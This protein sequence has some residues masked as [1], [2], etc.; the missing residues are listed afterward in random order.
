MGPYLL[1]ERIGEGGMG[2]VWKAEQ[3]A[4]VRRTVALKL[5]K[6][7]MDSR[8]VLARFE[9]ERQA[10]ALM[11]HPCIAKVFDAGTTAQG[12]PYFAME[13]VQ[14]TPI[15]EYCDRRRL[16]T[17]QRLE[18]F[19][20]V[21][22]GVQHAHQ[23]AVL[24][25][26]L[27]PS[28]IL[29]A[30][31][32]EKPLPKIIDFGVAKATT[33]K[34]T[35]RTMYTAMG[36][37]IGT[38]EYMSPEQAELTGEDVDTR[39]DVYSLG[40]VLYELMVG[41][42]PFEP[43]ELRKA[44][45]E[46]IRKMIREQDPPRPSTKLSTLGEQT[47][48]IAQCRATGPKRLSSQLKG[49]LDWIVMRCL[50]KDRN[51]R[52]GSPQELGQDVRR[53]LEHEPVLAGPPSPAY[54]AKKFVRRNRLGVSVAAA[55]L[56]VLVAF[57]A[58]TVVQSRRIATERD[59]A[60]QEAE[61][62]ERVSAFLAE[63][64][65]DINPHRLG[66]TLFKR[67]RTRVAEEQRD[68]IDRF[69]FGVNRADV[70]SH[71]LREEILGRAS[72]TIEVRL[73]DDPL[74][75]ANLHQTLGTSYV[76]IG[77]TEDAI[78]QLERAVE[79]RTLELGPKHPATLR[80]R[81]DHAVAHHGVLTAAS[82]PD[83]EPLSRMRRVYEDRQDI[84]GPDHPE[85]LES[86][87]QL[88][89]MHHATGQRAQADSVHRLV[90]DSRLR[91][92]GADHSR[93]LVSMHAVA[94]MSGHMSRWDEADSLFSIALP[95][96]ERALGPDDRETLA[97]KLDMAFFY[98]HNQ[99][100]HELAARLL[101]DVVEARR[102]LLGRNHPATM[103]AAGVLADIY[104]EWH[105]VEENERIQEEL[106]A[107]KLELFGTDHH[108]TYHSQYF[109]AQAHMR[110]GRFEDADRLFEK[111]LEGL[112]RTLSDGPTGLVGYQRARGAMNRAAGRLDHA[113][114]ILE[115][116][117]RVER[118]ELGRAEP[119]IESL[120]STYMDL[121][122]HEDAER[123]YLDR[124]AILES[125]PE[126][127]APS[128][129]Y[130]KQQLGGLYQVW[131]RHADAEPLLRTVVEERAA[132]D[133][134]TLRSLALLAQS[135][136]SKGRDEE[137]GRLYAQYQQIQFDTAAR[138]RTNVRSRA[139]VV[140]ALLDDVPADHLDLGQLI[141]HAERMNEL[142][143][144]RA[145]RLLTALAL[146]YHEAGRNSEAVAMQHKAL[147]LWYANDPQ[148]KK[149]EAS[150]EKFELAGAEGDR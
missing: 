129:L 85:T 128:L 45:F 145:P 135:M 140:R 20:R 119:P 142:T 33:Q 37:L 84:L 103:Y 127:D 109:L 137:A 77:L 149:E 35:E 7:G 65:G 91:V 126:R 10:L 136:E 90:Y 138:S 75:A 63:M 121:E 29:V 64:I 108:Q 46:G 81:H 17:V 130:W 3:T 105:R 31:V 6:A 110:T 67:L 22:E 16:S 117:L 71:L 9:A 27:K 52:Y 70:A 132:G 120:I 134:N 93:S 100:Q 102:S 1:R 69:L 44:G 58:M 99:W 53:H 86:L 125:N 146:A 88:G 4:P 115:E 92:L 78:A 147:Q 62:S 41:A 114:Q 83:I 133:Q 94:D 72:A 12:R 57:T 25:R 144:Y 54:R 50:E 32:D 98:S 14:G 60:N 8:E 28:N 111:A 56:I 61:A 40:V 68:E 141:P 106:L 80:A 11:D 30:D 59:R 23:K 82:D 43:R 112:A 21:C 49:D 13:Y 148:R 2:E 96:L 124:I 79:I 66:N 101:S 47:T 107:L 26:D 87:Y 131:G 113:A 97:C 73:G 42:L 123:L 34:L 143:N 51:R 36:Q 18:L 55:A 19:Q 89:V 15:T 48:Q 116:V 122:R 150:L 139:Q 24:H 76:R 39:T 118:E 74:I 38:P 95:G 104:R 5:I